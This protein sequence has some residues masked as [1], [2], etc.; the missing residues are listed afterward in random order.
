MLGLATETQDFKLVDLVQ[1]MPGCCEG[2]YP[3]TETKT[4]T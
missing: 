1:I 2:N 4:L 3:K